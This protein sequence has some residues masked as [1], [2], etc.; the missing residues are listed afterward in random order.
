MPCTLPAGR[1]WIDTEFSTKHRDYKFFILVSL[2]NISEPDRFTVNRLFSSN[3]LR[4][5]QRPIL[6]SS[7]WP[8][9]WVISSSSLCI[10]GVCDASMGTLQHQRRVRRAATGRGSGV[11]ILLPPP[12]ES[13][14]NLSFEWESDPMSGCSARDSGNRSGRRQLLDNHTLV[15]GGERSARRVFQR[16]RGLDRYSPRSIKTR[17]VPKQ[18]ITGFVYVVAR[19]FLHR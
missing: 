18:S 15:R 10:N 16:T 3:R 6:L 8:R 7:R 13:S 4:A 5:P 2:G 12:G 17:R 1:Y 9:L 19:T 11:R 14:A